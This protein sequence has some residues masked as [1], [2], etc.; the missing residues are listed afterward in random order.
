MSARR[1]GQGWIKDV[2]SIK[3]LN[4]H[5]K[6]GQGNNFQEEEG[7]KNQFFLKRKV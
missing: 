6:E 1:V 4:T 7:P 3:I 2:L 5:P